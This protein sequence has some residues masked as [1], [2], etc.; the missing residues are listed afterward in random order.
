MRKDIAP[1]H[2]E[3]FPSRQAARGLS[4]VY[5]RRIQRAFSRRALRDSDHVFLPVS[6]SAVG[7][8]IELASGLLLRK[9]AKPDYLATARGQVFLFPGSE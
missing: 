5:G 4:A 2:G 6:L 7:K 1:A 3:R 8:L 9:Q